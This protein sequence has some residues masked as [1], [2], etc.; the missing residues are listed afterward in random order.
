MA[1]KIQA[2]LIDDLDGSPAAETVSFALDGAVYE[3]DLSVAHAGEFRRSLEQ[4]VDAGR[5][6]RAIRQRRTSARTANGTSKSSEVR[7]WAKAH[8]IEVRDRGRVP[9][10]LL[11]KFKSAAHS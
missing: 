10:E 3:I 8:G 1:K 4:Y 6:S 11:V 5:P 7:E 9:A 2:V